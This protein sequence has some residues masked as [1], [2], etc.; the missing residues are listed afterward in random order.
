M[1]DGYVTISAHNRQQQ[2]TCELI[3]RGRRHVNLSRQN[4]R[5]NSIGHKNLVGVEVISPCT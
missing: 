4:R 3:D 5:G 1:A 2:G